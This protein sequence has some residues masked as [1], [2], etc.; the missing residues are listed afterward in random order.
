M[1]IQIVAFLPSRLCHLLT[2]LHQPHQD[3]TLRTHQAVLDFLG[4]KNRIVK[5]L[6]R[7]DR[8]SGE[9]P[10]ARSVL[11]VVFTMVRSGLTLLWCNTKDS[12]GYVYYR[13][14]SQI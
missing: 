7:K 3:L 9:S 6:R 2:T 4:M 8:H 14:R 13:L 11:R 5:I 1:G 10:A 12:R